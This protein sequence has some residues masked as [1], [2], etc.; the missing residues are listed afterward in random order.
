MVIAGFGLI[1][2]D[3]VSDKVS[4]VAAE[5]VIETVAG[6]SVDIDFDGEEGELSVSVTNE[7]GTTSTWDVS[8]EGQELPEDFPSEVYLFSDTKR[9]V[10]SV[11]DS[12]DG[13]MVMFSDTAYISL[14]E[15]QETIKSEMSALKLEAEIN[16]GPMS[17]FSYVFREDKNISVSLME[18][19]EN[20]E[21]VVVQY[22]VN[23]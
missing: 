8:T 5:A 18:D 4:E 1:S 10:L 19:D 14:K 15:A 6:D 23:Y 16:A 22:L 21:Y 13:K 7:D 2:C 20:H 11:V 3:S 17:T 12:E 9:G